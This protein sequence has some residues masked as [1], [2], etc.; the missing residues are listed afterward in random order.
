M[1]TYVEGM[2]WNIIATDG[3]YK[4][5]TPRML[6]KTLAADDAGG[7]SGTGVQPWFPTAGGVLVA[8]NTMYAFEGMLQL[9]TGATTHTTAQA[10]GGTAV[11]S[12]IMYRYWLTSA[13]SGAITTAASEAVVTSTAAFVMNA[14]ST[15]AET[16]VEVFG[17]VRVTTAGTFIPQFQFNAAP[18][19]TITSKRNSFFR[20]WPTGDAS[21]VSVGTWA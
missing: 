9:T 4:A 2:G 21:A 14:T 10:F 12:S 13:A 3:A 11:I 7:V 15:A 17:K 8:S 19:G 20:M 1:L 18:T 6:F 5:S 16:R